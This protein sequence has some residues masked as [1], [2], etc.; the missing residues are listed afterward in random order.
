MI[1]FWNH[2]CDQK[3]HIWVCFD[4]KFDLWWITKFDLLT[5]HLILK[6]HIWFDNHTFDFI[7]THLVKSNTHYMKS[8]LI[9]NKSYLRSGSQIWFYLT[10][11]WYEKIIFDF[12]VY[13]HKFDFNKSNLMSSNHIWFSRNHIWFQTKHIM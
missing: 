4:L 9:W 10:H 2:I 3:N 12:K 13:N 5:S 7:K 1:C 8:Y 11:I 6:S